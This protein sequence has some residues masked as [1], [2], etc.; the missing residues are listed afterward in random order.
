MQLPEE[1]PTF[2]Y[3]HVFQSFV[4][5]LFL[6][7]ILDLI[8]SPLLPGRLEESLAHGCERGPL[9][10]RPHP[11]HQRIPVLPLQADLDELEHVL[12]RGGHVQCEGSCADV[13]PAQMPA[14]QKNVVLILYVE[15]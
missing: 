8:L 14:R 4:A 10:D 1:A 7:K 15:C 11:W 3:L 9:A 5:R 12:V 6:K 2:I 13:G